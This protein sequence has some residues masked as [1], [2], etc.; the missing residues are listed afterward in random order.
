LVVLGV[1]G[2]AP[3]SADAQSGTSGGTVQGQGTVGFTAPVSM[4][5]QQELAQAE[6]T[7]N[8]VST[9]SQ[10]V[11]NR[12][13]QARQQ[14]DVVKMLCLNDKLS[15]IDVAARTVAERKS[16]LTAAVGRNDAELSNHEYTILTVIKQRVDQLMTEANQ[17]VG[18]EATSTGASVTFSEDPNLPGG[19]QT[20]PPWGDTTT[21]GGTGG[22][23]LLPTNPIPPPTVCSPQQ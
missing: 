4:T 2:Y 11:A 7:V 19:D 3:L 1:L 13:Q 6:A 18:E 21:P 10:T 5:P 12:L 15:Q 9:S 22:N 16:Q 20:A 17:C 23:P 8:Y 14:K